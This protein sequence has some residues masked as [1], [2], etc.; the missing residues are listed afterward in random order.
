MSVAPDARYRGPMAQIRGVCLAAMLCM[1]AACG[2]GGDGGGNETPPPPDLSGV[3]SGAWQGSDPTLG[4]V[5]GTWTVTINQGANSAFGPGTLL[6]DVDCMDGQMQTNPGAQNA[7][8]GSVTRA[9]CGA[10]SWTLTALRVSDGVAAGTWRNAQTG[11]TGS[12]SG[13]RIATLNG[14]RILFVSPPGGKSGAW[15]TVVGQSLP[16]SDGLLFNQAIQGTLQSADAT[17]IVARVPSGATSGP[18]QLGSALSPLLFNLDVISPPLALAGSITQGIA[19]A[20]LAV[21][22]DGRKFYIADRANNTVS[23]VRASTLVNIVTRAVPGGSP[24]SVVASPDGKRIYVA[25]AGIG[26]LVMDAAIA[27]EVNR[28]A[29]LIDDGGRDNPQ[30]IALSPDGRLLAVSDGRLGGSVSVFSISGDTLTLTAAH[31]LPANLAPLGVAFAPDGTQAHVAAADPVG[32]D[33]SLRAF[34]PASGA[35]IDSDLVG[36]LPTAVAVDPSGSLV[37]VSNRNGNSVSI[38]NRVTQAVVGSPITV[39]TAPTGI[40]ISP[41]GARVYVAN[42]GSSSV[43]VLDGTSGAAVSGSPLVVAAGPLAI[44]MNASGTTA[45]VGQLNSARVTEVG[46]MRT[47]TVNR[48]GTG[49]GSVRSTPAGID[50]GTSCQAQFVVGT[51][52]SLSAS[53][54]SGSSFAGWSGA[55]C[56]GSVTLNASTT[57]TAFFNSNSPPPSQQQQQ[58]SEDCFIATAAY[59]SGMAREVQLLREFRDRRL[60]ASAPGRGLVRFYYRNSPPLADLIRERDAARAAVR[61]GLV[62]VVW[63][64]EHPAAALWLAGFCVLLV[65]GWR[66]RAGTSRSRRGAA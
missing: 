28:S 18:I 52:V 43:S 42:S 56:G 4:Q 17:R 24:R 26:V 2:G 40:A 50:C 35:L 37:F 31:T 45:Y 33:D 41:D 23:V 65:V 47:L 59:G 16:S 58:Q 48:A 62:P 11:G 55:G 22:P 53:A 64:I 30:G 29:L 46:G 44:A 5:S 20:A 15:V 1:L 9:P 49:I 61:A 57:C 14:P 39:G 32:A 10:V 13:K 60:L 3:W 27:T 12:M 6:G 21:S 66:A 8:T 19:P 34:D 25:A 51:V 7:V 63:S 54:A 38:Y 36:D